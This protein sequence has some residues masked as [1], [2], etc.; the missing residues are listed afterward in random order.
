MARLDPWWR[1]TAL[2]L[3][4]LLAL[5]C[6]GGGASVG[7]DD[8]ADDDASDDDVADDDSAADDDDDD[9]PTVPR[10]A[11]FIGNSH[12]FTNDLPGMLA[13]LAATSALGLQFETA[14]LTQG[15]AT[16]E[17]LWDAGQA[18][19]L[20]ASQDWTWVVLQEQSTRPLTEPELMWEAVREFDALIDDQGAQTT[21]F[22]MWAREDMAWT[23][24]SITDA[25]VT[26][27]LEVDALIAPVGIAWEAALADQPDLALHSNDGSHPGPK[28]TYLA[29]CVFFA[30][31]YDLSPEGLGYGMAPGLDEPTAAFLQQVAWDTVQTW[32]PRCATRWSTVTDPWI[33]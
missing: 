31:F 18:A 13:E 26:V 8:A 5:G 30:V 19:D 2:L 29:A 14:E 16:L 4:L 10:S 24:D 22:L 3:G 17:S 20:I 15:G 6:E 23:Q 27:G 1:S 21:L 12:T 32:T 7:D 11:L 33:A 25:Y 9:D 28:G